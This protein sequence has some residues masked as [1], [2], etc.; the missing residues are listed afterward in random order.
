MLKETE[1]QEDSVLDTEVVKEEEE[2]AEAEAEARSVED[3]EAVP[4]LEKEA[5]PVMEGLC[6]AERE[7]AAVS[8]G[9]LD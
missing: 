1:A 7:R 6:W 5:L 4:Q 2:Q 9:L 8:V 3:P